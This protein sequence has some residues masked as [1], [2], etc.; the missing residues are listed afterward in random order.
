MVTDIFLA[1][2]CTGLDLLTSASV[3]KSCC[4]R[5]LVSAADETEIKNIYGGE[6]DPKVKVLA[7]PLNVPKCERAVLEILRLKEGEVTQ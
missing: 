6:L 3:V 1:G 7:K 5:M 2:S 4:A